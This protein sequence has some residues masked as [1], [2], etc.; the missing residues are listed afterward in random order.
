VLVRIK[1]IRK[2]AQFQ[3]IDPSP[4]RQMQLLNTVFLALIGLIPFLKT[5]K[6]FGRIPC[7]LL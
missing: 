5:V 6:F 1:I 4:K 2:I 3:L 7:G